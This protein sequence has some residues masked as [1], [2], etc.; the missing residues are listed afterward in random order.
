MIR[1]INP[2]TKVIPYEHARVADLGD[3]PIQNIFDLERLNGEIT[4]FYQRVVDAQVVPLSV[5]DHSISFPILRALGRKEAPALIH[6][7][8]HYDM[9]PPLKGT[10]FHHGAPF[11]N[12]IEEGLIDAAHS[13]QIAIRDPYCEMTAPFAKEAGV[14]VI[15]MADIDGMGIPAVIE[16]VRRVVGDRPVYLSFDIDA[17]DPTLAPGTGTP[18]MGG[19]TTR[20][21]MRILQGLSDLRLVGADVVE[22]S[23]PYDPTGMTALLGAQLLF[24]ILC[25]T[26]KSSRVP[27][28]PR[29]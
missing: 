17:I 10:K 22:V 9:A 1:Y 7:D 23:P 20:E 3:V 16:T 8:S 5:G 15:E 28:K 29:R 11:R 4:A 19:L 12:A 13:V 6:F 24:E 21:A 27:K 14:T 26:A 18:V 25:V 2:I